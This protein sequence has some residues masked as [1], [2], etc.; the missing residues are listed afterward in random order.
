MNNFILL[1]NKIVSVPFPKIVNVPYGKERM[2]AILLRGTVLLV[3]AL[4]VLLFIN[5]IA[6]NHIQY[7]RIAVCLVI[8]MYLA[9][10]GM[11]IRKNFHLL[12]AWLLISL[13]GFF[14]TVIIIIWSLNASIGILSIS[15]TVILAGTILGTKNL[16][17]V[18]VGI[19]T[20][21]FVIQFLHQF[22]IIVPDTSA[23]SKESHLMDVFA[24]ATM[25][26]IFALVSWLS[27][28]QNEHSLNRAL[29]AEIKVKKEKTKLA[30]KLYEQSLE[31]HQAQ[32]LEMANLYKFASIGQST[33][34]TLHELSNQLSILTM[35]ID[36]LKLKKSKSKA[37]ANAK[38]SVANI[39]S[40]VR[41]TRKRLQESNDPIRFNVTKT[42]NKTIDELRP[43][44][45]SQ[46]MDIT[47][48]YT[49]RTARYI[50]GDES[51]LSHVITILINNALDASTHNNRG[52]IKVDIVE[53]K[54]SFE[55]LVVD[56]GRGLSDIGDHL[57][58]PHKSNKPNG[59]GIGL[60]I[61][62]QII[63]NQFN[64]KI[65]AKSLENGSEFKLILPKLQ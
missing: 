40:L 41:E 22:N 37:L 54:T 26:C 65:E 3:T 21:L 19:V 51:N 5:G 42:I 55:V 48:L 30:D 49:T 38:E 34:A 59:L 60:Y 7:A 52:K 13:Y 35:D 11:L 10:I 63:E 32:I 16:P 64:G 18:T 1:I 50:F 25:I 14:A 12:S 56:N 61:T 57:F 6:A 2:T 47:K 58:E 43:K 53:I 36:D 17:K 28:K 44:L 31:L 9:L 15:F 4:T 46:H 24:Y 45:H 62:K 27:G 29:D 8:F 20:V 33:T 39:N 23:L